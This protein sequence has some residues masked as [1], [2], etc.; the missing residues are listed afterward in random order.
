MPE[1]RPEYQRWSTGAGASWTPRG[2]ATGPNQVLFGFHNKFPSASE[3]ARHVAG[4]DRWAMFTLEQPPIELENVGQLGSSPF[5]FDG[6]DPLADDGGPPLQ[7][8]AR[9]GAASGA[10]LR[11]T[12]PYFYRFL[13]SYD[14]SLAHI[15]A[16]QP[17]I[18]RS[19]DGGPSAFKPAANRAEMTFRHL[20]P[21]GNVLS[22]G[23]D[24]IS[25]GNNLVSIA[26]EAQT[27]GTGEIVRIDPRVVTAKGETFLRPKDLLLDLH[28][29]EQVT[30]A[31]IAR[32]GQG[33]NA[34]QRLNNRMIA[35]GRAKQ[36]AGNF[37]EGQGVGQIPPEAVSGVKSAAADLATMRA[38]QGIR[39]GG[40]ILMVY[41]AYKSVDRIANAPR[42]VRP[43]V[44][45]Q[46]IG[47]WAG[48]FG[49]AW[50]V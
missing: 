48:G 10:F 42:E 18:P 23:T 21:G 41:G 26:K 40:G 34:M 20:R 11:A 19:P 17:L 24:R 37:G 8:P 3:L 50:A 14:P 15:M 39:V 12:W 22:I 44:A 1:Y 43:R 38:M 2:A 25:T 36:Y 6:R 27:R 16:G 29:F 5:D 4:F 47:G 33:K 35:I 30:R 31:E 9:N 45:T 7:D 46:E 13:A 32:G 49:G 28:E